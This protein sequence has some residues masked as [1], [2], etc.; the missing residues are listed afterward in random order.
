MR[1][2]IAIAESCTGGLLMA[3]LTQSPGASEFLLGGVVA[4]SNELKERLLHVSPQTLADFGAVSKETVVEMCEGLFQVTSADIGVAV[5]GIFGPGGG[6]EEKPIGT[7]WMAIGK[8]GEDPQAALIPLENNLSR[9]EYR[10]KVVAYLQEA[11]WKQ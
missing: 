9:E 10:N 6:S 2:K 5:S 4:Y 3:T 7:V 1:K 11:L 8:R